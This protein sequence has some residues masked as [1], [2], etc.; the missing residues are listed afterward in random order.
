MYYKR[1]DLLDVPN[2]LTVNCDSSGHC[3]ATIQA[4]NIKWSEIYQN[5]DNKNYP[6]LLVPIAAHELGHALGLGHHGTPGSN[7]ALMTQSTTRTTPNSIDIGPLPACSG[8]SGASGVR[9]IY[10]ATY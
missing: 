3:S 1:D 4:M 6:S 2:G 7:V 5:I 8:S 10:D 9:C